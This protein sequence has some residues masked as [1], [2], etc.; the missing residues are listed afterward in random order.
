MVNKFDPYKNFGFLTDR[1]SRL[2]HARVEQVKM[3]KGFTFPNSCLGVL[4]DLWAKDGIRQ[5]DLADALIRNKSSINKMLVAL[6]KDG[7]IKRVMDENDRRQNR[8]FLTRKGNAFKSYVT[9]RASLGEKIATA[10]LSAKDVETTKKVLHM[11]YEN[12]LT[13]HNS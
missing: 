11:I 4:A 5:Q 3:E 7:L 6:E 1:V 9:K 8:I 13:D 2:I 10:G 12:L